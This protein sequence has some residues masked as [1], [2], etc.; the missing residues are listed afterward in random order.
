MDEV[1]NVV[2]VLPF[3]ALL[4]A[5]STLYVASLGYSLGLYEQGF[6]PG[7]FVRAGSTYAYVYAVIYVLIMTGVAYLLWYIKN[8]GLVPSRRFDK[9]LFVVLVVVTVYIYMRLTA[10]FILNF[11]LPNVLS[12]GIGLFTLTV[13]IYASC[14][15]SLSIYLWRPVLS[16]V[17]TDGIEKEQA[18]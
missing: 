16:W 7:F 11:L 6:F 18:G 13:I 14:A 17:R 4:D 1:D 2:W 8:R 3:L 5:V 9:G 15:L 12:S 10:A